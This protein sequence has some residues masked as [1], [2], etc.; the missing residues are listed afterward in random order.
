MHGSLVAGKF[1]FHVRIVMSRNDSIRVL[2]SFVLSTFVGVLCVSAKD[3]LPN[4]AVKLP[5]ID[6]TDRVFVPIAAEKELAHAWVGEIVQGGQGFMW[7][8]TRDSLIR[9]DGHQIRR[10]TPGSVGANGIFVQECCRYA[11]FRDHSGRIWIGAS[12]SVY[13]YDPEHE[14]F[15]SPPIASGKLQGLV[16][17]IDEDRAGTMWFATSRGLTRYNPAN[18]ETTQLLHAENNP[19]T[20]G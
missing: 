11:L 10:Y 18:G 15:T 1:Q 17:G 2:I 19:A 9:Y 8:S 3:M 4:A 6:V 12:D 13:R 7:F 5:I 20:L 16:R 14:K